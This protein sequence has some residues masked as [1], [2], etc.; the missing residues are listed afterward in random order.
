[1]AMSMTKSFVG[2]LA[3]ML[4][5]E[6]VIDPAAPVTKYLPEMQKTAYGDATVRQVMDMT[7]GAKFSEDYPDPNAEVWAYARAGGMKPRPPGYE[8]PRSFYEFLRAPCPVGARTLS[9]KS[10]MPATSASRPV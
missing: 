10:V 5:H 1:M 8:G 4:A 6:G 2:T 3:A 9:G 7:I